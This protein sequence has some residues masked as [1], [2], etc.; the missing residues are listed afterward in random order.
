[1][2]SDGKLTAATVGHLTN[3][4]GKSNL[5][6]DLLHLDIAKFRSENCDTIRFKYHENCVWTYTSKDHIKRTY[7]ESFNVQAVKRQLNGE[8]GQKL[9]NLIGNNIVYF[10]VKYAQSNLT[11]NIQTVGMR[12]TK[13]IH[14]KDLEDLHSR[15]PY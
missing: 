11:P 6:S 8:E 4:T 9:M 3:I 15:T 2:Q 10:V 12:N 13:V 14:Q 5:W 1:M 7:L